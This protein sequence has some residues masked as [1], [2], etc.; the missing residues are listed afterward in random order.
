MTDPPNRSDLEDRLGPTTKPTPSEF[1]LGRWGW[2][3]CSCVA[4]PAA[5]GTRHSR[6]QPD[7][8]SPRSS[9]RRSRAPAVDL[10]L[11]PLLDR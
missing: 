10:N 7:E 4:E 9:N 3:R 5:T 1:V 11:H 8:G 2:T 6:Q